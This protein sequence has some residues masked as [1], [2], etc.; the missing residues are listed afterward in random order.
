[1]LCNWWARAPDEAGDQRSGFLQA[2]RWRG[3]QGAWLKRFRLPE[4]IFSPTNPAMP[5]KAVDES[6]AVDGIQL[7]IAVTRHLFP[8]PSP[9]IAV[10]VS[11]G[12]GWHQMTVV[13]SDRRKQP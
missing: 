2:G 8:S 6:P 7:F 10:G 4:M 13:P 1:M 3:Q 5:E 11:V 9:L 12:G